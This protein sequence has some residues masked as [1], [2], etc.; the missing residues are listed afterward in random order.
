M[1]ARV[2]VVV[3][4]RHDVRIAVAVLEKPT[5]GTRDVATA[6]HGE[7]AALAEVI[8]YVNDDQ[9][10]HG[11]TVSSPDAGGMMARAG[12]WNHNVHYQPVVLQAVPAGCGA[13]LEVGCGDGLLAGGRLTARPPEPTGCILHSST[14][15]PERRTTTM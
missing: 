14:G 1:A 13:A 4:G 7:R 12:N 15:N 10:A 2:D 8:L 11:P 9:C 5:D 6:V 3:V